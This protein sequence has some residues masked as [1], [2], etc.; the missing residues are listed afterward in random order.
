MPTFQSFRRS[1]AAAAALLALQLI[2]PWAARAQNATA[3]G[4]GSG[5]AIPRGL[6]PRK[7]LTQYPLDVWNEQRGLPNA[8]VQGLAQTD[9]GYLWIGTEEGLAR[10]DGVAFT[11][12][13]HNTDPAFF[14]DS[15]TALLAAPAGRLWVGTAH[16]LLRYEK[17]RFVPVMPGGQPVAGL[18]R[19]I[20]LTDDGTLWA[21]GSAGLFRIGR[22]GTSEAF[23]KARG[24]PDDA[25]WSIVQDAAR[26]VWV[27]TRRGLVRIEGRTTTTFGTADGLPDEDVRALALGPDGTLWVGSVSGLARLDT[28]NGVRVARVDGLSDKTVMALSEDASGT[29]WVGT[30]LGGLDAVRGGKVSRIT[31][32]DGL[33][34][35]DVQTMLFDREGNL[36]LGGYGGLSRL[37][38]GMFTTLGARAGLAS[39]EIW[40]VMEDR[41]GVLWVGTQSGLTRYDGAHATNYTTR[42]GLGHNSIVALGEGRDGSIWVGTHGGG[43]GRLKDGRIRTFTIRDGLSSNDI[44][45][46][47]EDPGGALWIG[48]MGGGLDRFDGSRFQAFRRE[49]GLSS[50]IVHALHQGTDGA[51][52]IGTGGGGLCRYAEGA[53]TCYGRQQ[54]LPATSVFDI[55]DDR[56]GALWLATDG[57]LV[58]F[59]KGRFIAYTTR[60]GLKA[61]KVWAVTAD[62]LGNLWLTSNK[63]LTKLRVNDV[64]RFVAGEIRAI[65]PVVYGIADGLPTKD[66]AGAAWPSSWKTRDGRILCATSK[67]VVFV[68]PAASD[69]ISLP[70]RVFVERVEI[71]QQVVD[72]TSAVHAP[73]GAGRL[74]VRFAAP[75]FIAP[76]RLRFAVRLDG[77]D[78][79]WIDVG[80]QH[81]ATYTNLEPG[82]YTFRVRVRTDAGTW[83]A[84]EAAFPFS[85]TPRLYQTRAF[86][87]L[88][89]LGA[90]LVLAAGVGWR[91]HRARVY[92]R[93]LQRRIDEAL[94]QVKALRGLIPMCSW[95]GRVRDDAGYWD[96]VESYIQSHSDAQI[97]HGLCPSC[98]DAHFPEMAREIRNE[99]AGG[100]PTAG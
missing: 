88:C 34:S 90:C 65:D 93:E 44:R 18:I 58:H 50:D 68:D 91:L 100:E 83:G 85:L 35:D 30:W 55:R 94:S 69:P 47:F 48:T 23:T 75:F 46:I 40:T 36:W 33:Q 62:A 22:D 54:G 20:V 51:L 92:Q 19:S 29:V 57:G 28:R 89:A 42:D 86:R 74:V 4:P 66:F 25:V 6:D 56:D 49:H 37:R 12:F 61:E 9:D 97:S 26:R 73:P 14:D 60:E 72:I 2:A 53:F 5:L 76:E 8:H 13:D 96:R 15:V 82:Q 31:A 79:D 3:V 1:S 95:C 67:G 80:T 99:E 45:V 16:G 84:A 64:R 10:F 17:G 43:L 70:P 38:D 11:V 59:A 32:A 81:E 78:P 24:L 71:D 52:W 27:G 87:V 41:A 63:G 39:S 98:L 77:S 21:G 7:D